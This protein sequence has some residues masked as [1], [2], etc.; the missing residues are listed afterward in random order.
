MRSEIINKDGLINYPVHDFLLCDFYH[1]L[2]G[3]ID[4][5]STSLKTIAHWYRLTPNDRILSTLVMSHG[6]Y[7]WR[8]G[9][10]DPSHRI[11]MV[12]PNCNDGYDIE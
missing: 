6:T 9:S 1:C 12:Y 4:Q 10:H 8:L 5:N 3:E 11:D 2:I 7:L